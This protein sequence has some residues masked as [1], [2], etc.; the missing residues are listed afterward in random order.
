M[1]SD[2]LK[3]PATPHLVW[4]GSTPPRQDKVLTRAEAESFLREPVIVEEKV[5]GANLGISFDA[6]GNMVA[7]NRGSL[8]ERGTKDQFAPLWSWLDQREMNLLDVLEDRFI[9]FGEWCYACHSIY[10]TR[11]PDYL[12]S[13]DVFDKRDQRFLNST[14]RTEIVGALRF[15]AVPVVCRGLFEFDEILGLIGQ[16][17]LY[18]GPMEGI[19]LRQ[20]DASWL[21]RRAKVVRPEFVQQIGDHWTKRPLIPNQTLMSHES[22][23]DQ[24]S[25]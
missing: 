4:L 17:S 9:L 11:L 6:Q 12:L 10:Y 16:S 3:F 21:V 2:F 18:D 25:T 8:L 13:F 15:S 7:Q 24:A 5:D 23:A 1:S 22:G 14:R 20:D 19:Y